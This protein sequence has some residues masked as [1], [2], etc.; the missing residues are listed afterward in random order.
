MIKS[1]AASSQRNCA[2]LFSVSGWSI[3]VWEAVVPLQYLTVGSLNWMI[4][5]FLLRS[6]IISRYHYPQHYQ[7]DYP[8][9]WSPVKLSWSRTGWLGGVWEL[10]HIT[11]SYPGS[12][13]GKLQYLQL[14]SSILLRVKVLPS[15]SLL[16][17]ND[18]P[19]W[20]W[21]SVLTLS[22]LIKIPDN[23]CI[24]W[25]QWPK[26]SWSQDSVLECPPVSELSPPRLLN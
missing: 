22:T 1:G 23:P 5:H 2:P 18:S 4:A 11:H 17:A 10:S 15:S 19:G 24:F 9:Q 7:W 16:I 14:F 21:F 26:T 3:V 13:T 12:A 8:E 6:T 25:L 20:I